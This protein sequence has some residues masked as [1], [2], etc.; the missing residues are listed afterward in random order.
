MSQ[1][2]IQVPKRTQRRLEK[3]TAAGKRIEVAN[4][5]QTRHTLSNRRVRV[6]P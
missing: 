5:L 1:R 2:Y 4:G 3:A 6:R